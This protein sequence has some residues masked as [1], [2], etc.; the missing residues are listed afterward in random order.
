VL[1]AEVALQGF[2]S[3]WEVRTRIEGCEPLFEKPSLEKKIR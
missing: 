3:E 2:G 1:Q